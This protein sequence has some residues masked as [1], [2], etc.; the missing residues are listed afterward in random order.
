MQHNYDS[1]SK[2]ADREC[3]LALCVKALRAEALSDPA[4]L[5]QQLIS[6]NTSF[7]PPWCNET[8]YPVEAVAWEG[9]RHSRL[10]AATILFH[11]IS[12]WLLRSIR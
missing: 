6:G 7:P 4:T 10:D 8:A 1:F 3:G 11:K 2:S 5:K 12:P 9:V